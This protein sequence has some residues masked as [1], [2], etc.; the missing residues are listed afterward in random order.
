MHHEAERKT[1][2]VSAISDA[3]IKSL[4]CLILFARLQQEGLLQSDCES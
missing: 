2:L 4:F 3:N 1:A